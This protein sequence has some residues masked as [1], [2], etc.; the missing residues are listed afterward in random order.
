MFRFKFDLIWF[1][2]VS[3][4]Y[5]VHRFYIRWVDVQTLPTQC[6][7]PVHQD[8]R[9]MHRLCARMRVAH[10]LL[11]SHVT[12]DSET[13]RARVIMKKKN[14]INYWLIS[15]VVSNVTPETEFR[16][17]YLLSI[18]FQCSHHIELTFFQCSSPPPHVHVYVAFMFVNPLLRIFSFYYRPQ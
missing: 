4:C 13:K 1:S 16:S 12:I 17:M 7:I 8:M 14:K 9:Y 18:G 5:S 6:Q 15:R 3:I 11:T 10:A 2:N